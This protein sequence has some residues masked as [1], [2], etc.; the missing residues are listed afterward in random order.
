MPTHTQT[1]NSLSCNICTY[2]KC[3]RNWFHLYCLGSTRDS[4]LLQI[5]TGVIDTPDISK[6]HDTLYLSNPRL[7]FVIELCVIYLLYYDVKMTSLSFIL[8]TIQLTKCFESNSK[9]GA[10]FHVEYRLNLPTVFSTDRSKFVCL[11]WFSVLFVV[12]VCFGV[13][14]NVLCM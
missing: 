2:Y 4:A 12:N 11:L 9:L 6:Y 3:I 7:S 8:R 14:F 13:V 5:F 1:L 10:R